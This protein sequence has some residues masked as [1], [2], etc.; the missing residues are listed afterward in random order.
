MINGDHYYILNLDIPTDDETI[1]KQDTQFATPKKR[2]EKRKKKEKEEFHVY[3]NK[4]GP[5]I[6]VEETKFWKKKIKKYLKPLDQDKNKEKAATEALIELRNS[7]C[8][9]VFLLNTILVTIMFSLTQVNTFKDTLSVKFTCGG[10]DV[11][12][13]PISIMFAAIFGLLLLMQFICMLYHR[14]STLIHITAETKIREDDHDKSMNDKLEI[15]DFLTNPLTSKSTKLELVSDKKR[16]V[17][18][19]IKSD[20]MPEKEAKITSIDDIIDKQV[21][22]LKDVKGDLFG[23]Q[24]Q[25]VAQLVINKWK[26]KNDMAGVV[27]QAVR[28]HRNLPKLNGGKKNKVEPQPSASSD[29]SSGPP[30]NGQLQNQEPTSGTDSNV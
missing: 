16:A 21:D 7:V 22:R 26:K 24:K 30:P 14:I 18:E 28:G 29:S 25:L 3:C 4:D 9:F 15:A 13:V 5:E 8:L 17:L 10:N 2:K 20:K 12:I 11:N 6:D 19:M 1:P 23:K 27:F